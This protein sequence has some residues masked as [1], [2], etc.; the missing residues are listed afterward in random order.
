MTAR[1][2]RLRPRANEDLAE[3]VRY[4]SGESAGLA[5]RFIDAVLAALDTLR[6]HPEM[7]APRAWRDER[8]SGLRTWPVPGF[9]RWLIFYRLTEASVDV[10]R[11]LHGARDL[12]EVL[13]ED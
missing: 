9:E 11:V 13:R 3:H 12:P 10:V 5:V 4:L 6:A 2:L 8:L 7:G 1:A